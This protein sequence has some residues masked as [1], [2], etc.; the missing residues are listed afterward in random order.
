MPYSASEA[1]LRFCRHVVCWPAPPLF[2]FLQR[3]ED[4]DDMLESCKGP[5]VHSCHVSPSPG[6]LGRGGWA[7]RRVVLVE[8][9]ALCLLLGGPNKQ[10]VHSM[11]SLPAYLGYL[12]W[13]QP[14]RRWSRHGGLR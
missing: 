11:G 13:L 12:L 14:E 3:L 6:G 2:S 5:V 7:G 8:P 4:N 9:E 10:P 1:A